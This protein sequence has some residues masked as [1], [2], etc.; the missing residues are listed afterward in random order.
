M[1]RRADRALLMAKENGRNQV[2]QLGTGLHGKPE[3]RA[4]DPDAVGAS[5][6]SI[7]LQQTLV[8]PVPTKMAMEKL[9]GFVADHEAT[10]AKIDGNEIQLEIT[11]RGE[12]R[13]RRVADR[14]LVF[15]IDLHFEEQ[16]A[17]REAQNG[18]ISVGGVLRTRIFVSI[19]PRRSRDRRR[20][21][22]QARAQQVL[23]SM[24]SYLMATFEDEAGP[25][26]DGALSK[27]KHA[28]LPWLG[29]KK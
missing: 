2:V 22:T 25:P 17:H 19:S 27:V 21:D 28:L 16:R 13:L 24:R 7:I 10:I 15:E 5:E 3:D 23:V 18:E 8:T 4:E 11:D 12:S 29:K 14:P 26:L 20:A 6:P 9:R 1:L